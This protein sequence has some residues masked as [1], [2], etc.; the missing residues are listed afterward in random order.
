MIIKGTGIVNLIKDVLGIRQ[1]LTFFIGFSL[2]FL[3][4]CSS[5]TSEVVSPESSVSQTASNLPSNETQFIGS[6]TTVPNDL[7]VIPEKLTN[8][9]KTDS[10]EPTLEPSSTAIPEPTSTAIPEP[11]ETAT[12]DPTATAKTKPTARLPP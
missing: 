8:P 10:P 3:S 9:T 12:P 1:F 5:T 11:T 4:A 2:L 6:G 7:T